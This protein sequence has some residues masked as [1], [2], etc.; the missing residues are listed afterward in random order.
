MMS[1]VVPVARTGASGGGIFGK[2][3]G[4]RMG[5]DRIRA[6]P[7]WRGEISVA[8]LVGGLSN[9]SWK[10]VDE[11]R[12]ACRAL[13]RRIFRSITSPRQR[14]HDGAG[15]PC[16]G[17]APE[18]EYA[19]PGVMVSAFLEA[20]TWGEAEVRADPDRVGAICASFTRR[21]R[22]GVRAGRHLLGLPCDPRLC[23]DAGG[24]GQPVRGRSAASIWRSPRRL[25]AAQVP[26][27]IVFGHTT[28]CPP[29]SSMTGT[30]GSG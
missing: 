19:A 23:P 27:P 3:K 18:V 26:L 16:G 13:R 24:K 21:C 10:V 8:P 11:R 20:R 12:R 15:G 17:F 7:C 1:A 5:I 22:A 9:E 29:I 2:M 6:L 4:R 14:G 30:G 28:C 25:E